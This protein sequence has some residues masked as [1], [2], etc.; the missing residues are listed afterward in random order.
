[1]P[2]LPVIGEMVSFSQP[3]SPVLLKGLQFD[4]EKPFEFNFIVDTGSQDISQEALKEE[5]EALIRFFLTGLAIPEEDFWVN[6]SPYEEHRIIAPDFGQ[7]EMGRD[8]LAQDYLLKQLS[9]SLLYPEKE[10]GQEFWS[11]VRSQ[12]AKKF[13]KSDAPLE[14]FH[15]VWI[16]PDKAQVAVHGQT[17]VISKAR[18]K[19]ML[20]KDYLAMTSNGVEEKNP[21]SAEAEEVY[22]QIIL[23]AIEQEVNA[24]K[25]FSRLRQIYYALILATWYRNTLRES[26]LMRVYGSKGKLRGVEHDEPEASQRIYE[27]Y[28]A[29]FKKGVYNYIREEE[30][31]LSQ[32][33]IPRKYFSGGIGFSSTNLKPAIEEV[34]AASA[35]IRFEGNSAILSGHYRFYRDGTSTGTGI[36]G[37]EDIL[38]RAVKSRLQA[39]EYRSSDGIFQGVDLE[40]FLVAQQRLANRELD[41]ERLEAVLRHLGIMEEDDVFSAGSRTAYYNGILLEL[42]RRGYSAETVDLINRSDG[43]YAYKDPRL[44]VTVLGQNANA[45]SQ[46]VLEAVANSIDALRASSDHWIGQFGKGVKQILSWLDKSGRDRIDVYS[47]TSDGTANHLQIVRDDHGQWYVQ[48]SAMTEQEFFS[49]AGESAEQGTVV[50]VSATRDLSAEKTPDGSS[51]LEQIAG[52]I[53]D[54]FRFVR[55]VRIDLELNGLKDHVNGWDRRRLIFG[56]GDERDAFGGR[57]IRVGLDAHSIRIVDNGKGMNVATLSRMFIPAE[58]GDKQ[59]ASQLTA[60]HIQN[61][62]DYLALAHEDMPE[63]RSVVAFSRNGEIIKEIEVPSGIHP[64]GIFKGRLMLEMGRLLQV[65]QARDKIIFPSSESGQQAMAAGIEQVVRQILSITQDRMTDIDKLRLINSLINGLQELAGD[66]PHN[67][68]VL[69]MMRGRVKEL[70]GRVVL[71]LSGDSKYLFFPDDVQFSQVALPQGVTAVYLNEFLFDW[72]DGATALKSLQA[73]AVSKDIISVSQR[74][75]GRETELT[76]MAVDFNEDSMKQLQLGAKDAQIPMIETGTVILVPKQWMDVVL[77]LIE[78]RERDGALSDDE[79][80]RLASLLERLSIQITK[81]EDLTTSYE[82]GGQRS[83]LQKK[84]GGSEGSGPSDVQPVGPDAAA[85][86]GFL[87][88]PSVKIFRPVAGEARNPSLKELARQKESTFGSFVD[89]IN[90]ISSEAGGPQKTGK[91]L[92][93]HRNAYFFEKGVVVESARDE[94]V[95]RSFSRDEFVDPDQQKA[96]RFFPLDLFVNYRFSSERYLFGN[97]LVVR[98]GMAPILNIGEPF[99]SDRQSWDVIDIR[100]GAVKNKIETNGLKTKL[101]EHP[102]SETGFF[103][104]NDASIPGESFQGTVWAYDCKNHSIDQTQMRESAGQGER[105]SMMRNG[106]GYLNYIGE[107]SWS[108]IAVHVFGVKRDPLDRANLDVPM[109]SG[110]P[111]YL[112]GTAKEGDRVFVVASQEA[113]PSD[114]ENGAKVLQDDPGLYWQLSVYDQLTG[115]L[116]YQGDFSGYSDSSVPRYFEGIE[117]KN[118]SVRDVDFILN[119][120][121]IS[122]TVAAPVSENIRHLGGG[123]FIQYS[124]QPVS[125]LSNGYQGRMY[126]FFRMGEN[127]QIISESKDHELADPGE[128]ELEFIGQARIPVKFDSIDDRVAARIFFNPLTGQAAEANLEDFLT[129]EIFPGTVKSLVGPVRHTIG[130]ETYFTIVLLDEQ[131]TYSPSGDVHL[132]LTPDGL[133]YQIPFSEF[134]KSPALVPP[135]GEKDSIDFRWKQEHGSPATAMNR[136]SLI[137]PRLFVL[138][139]APVSRPR[140]GGKTLE[141]WNRLVAAHR[142]EWIGRA[143]AVYGPLLERVPDRLQR[144][145]APGIFH[146]YVS[147]SRR[148]Q[149]QLKK[150]IDR[151]EGGEPVELG[152]EPFSKMAERMGAFVQAL[153]RVLPDGSTV[154]QKIQGRFEQEGRKARADL[155]RNFFAGLMAL[156]GA[157]HEV[158][159]AV[160]TEEFFLA[161][162][163]G[164]Y[165]RTEPLLSAMAPVQALIG[166]IQGSGAEHVSKVVQILQLLVNEEGVDPARFAGQ[167]EKMLQY[168]RY[169]EEMS[170]AFEGFEQDELFRALTDPEADRGSLGIL[171]DFFVFLVS[172]TEPIAKKKIEVFPGEFHSIDVTLDQLAMYN[173]SKPRRAEQDT[174]LYTIDDIIANSEAVSRQTGSAKLT[175][176]IFKLVEVQREAGAYAAEIAQNSTDAGAR[177]L[178]IEYYVDERSGMYV[179]EIWDDGAGPP[180]G[181]ALALLIPQSNKAEAGQD[182]QVVG[183][184]GTGKFTMYAGM[185]QVQ[186]IMNNGVESFVFDVEVDYERRKLVLV[187]ITKIPSSSVKKGVGIRRMR[188]PGK[189]LPE[190]EQMIARRAWKMHA[191]MSA[192]GEFNIRF[193]KPAAEDGTL[194]DADVLAVR[195]KEALAS[196]GL[197]V[198]SLDE[199]RTVE[200]SVRVWATADPDMPMQV[201]DRRGL[202]ID[203]L[204]EKEHFLDLVPQKLRRYAKQIGLVIQ[205]DAPLRLIQNRSSFMEEDV[206]LPEI[207]KSVA[208]AFYRALVSRGLSKETTFTLDEV[209]RDW[210]VNPAEHYWNSVEPQ[211]NP[212]LMLDGNIHMFDV[213]G[214]I[215]QELFK[216]AAADSFDYDRLESMRDLCDRTDDVLTRVLVLIEAFVPDEQGR[217]QANSYLQRRIKTQ[218]KIDERRAR[219][220]AQ[221]TGRDYERSLRSH[222][223]HAQKR[224]QVA[225]DMEESQSINPEDH[226]IDPGT[227]PLKALLRIGREVAGP[228]GLQD[229]KIVSGR[230]KRLP[231]SGLF[232]INMAGEVTMYLN[233]DTLAEGIASLSGRHQATETVVHEAAHFLEHLVD[234]G[235]LKNLSGV[236]FISEKEES[237]FTHGKRFKFFMRQIAAQS[238]AEQAKKTE[239]G[240]RTGERGTNSAVLPGEGAPTGGIDLTDID[241]ETSAVTDQLWRRWTE[242]LDAPELLLKEELTGLSPVV[243]NV[244]PHAN[245]MH[246][247]GQTP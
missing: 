16:M 116:I 132:L 94:I 121:K 141:A 219:L 163:Y 73:R 115:K 95:F 98:D 139:R 118:G 65:Q 61:E 82:M 80:I 40:H 123:L 85:I 195:G 79:Q 21:I 63:E 237:I 231:F 93:R 240:R 154:W 96:H 20:E 130:K 35:D 113:L 213:I 243:V 83:R 41:D 76:L 150:Q 194:Q 46:S 204:K 22:R 2:A 34:P 81:E 50:E 182:S 223:P 33:I 134:V 9:A 152:Y 188:A 129:A 32:Q 62:L 187:E 168:P 230:G 189:S 114:I 178:E 8:L 84:T 58:G 155:Y 175:E 102:D 13:G 3:F 153:D 30:D 59:A 101:I 144:E 31:P 246:F 127:G 220:A 100:T 15:K 124:M 45:K 110:R 105:I 69:Q 201:V 162:S 60:E 140:I 138:G 70:I 232:S 106:A 169:I 97:T 158:N 36:A 228:L 122:D 27:Q 177:N 193:L 214:Q 119:P 49:K 210:E 91:Y 198:R 90:Y 186:I 149:E 197:R 217:P 71:K 64:Q 28:V 191:G 39:T 241:V 77:D 184:F 164:W 5:G 183:F 176:E 242:S 38:A 218:A 86:E 207:Q 55:D 172:D 107:E 148:I 208:V 117:K 43:G 233:A 128:F 146:L 179:E 88:E 151:A 166:K 227:E 72:Q 92:G 12:I 190:L 174:D 212:G 196:A 4:I 173:R 1:M 205:I 6:L 156:A 89:M 7:T 26:M 159:S 74:V 200:G 209:P 53:K 99:G 211:N 160:L 206:V 29:S 54:R 42:T 185:D 143:Q 112:V 25:S 167:L 247:L 104:V 229:V 236:F 87:K 14:T 226:V 222:D 108:N 216:G 147:E 11:T 131:R 235:G 44:N 23:P 78:K 137:D 215:N 142:A 68:Q 238:L 157:D 52:S 51:V 221:K 225:A 125:L 244:L 120:K 170:R 171:N 48:V 109:M 234:S 136:L 161:L 66:N 180:L 18:L 135:S 145:M 203:S 56:F 199:G 57:H 37:D 126:R 224:A 24:G 10:L 17:A 67:Q 239:G 245:V 19:V 47:K 165:P 111:R 202:R 181:K 103:I 192:G 133:L 75:N